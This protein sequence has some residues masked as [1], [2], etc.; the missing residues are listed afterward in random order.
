[1]SIVDTFPKLMINKT[2]GFICLMYSIHI[3]NG[4][5]IWTCKGQIIDRNGSVNKSFKLGEKCNNWA[6]HFFEPYN[7]YIR[8]KKYL[9]ELK[10]SKVKFLFRKETTAQIKEVKKKIELRDKLE[11]TVGELKKLGFNIVEKDDSFKIEKV[12]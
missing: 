4:I 11:H 5:S 9:K 12:V 6:F 7:G 3:P 10:K 2:Y 1:M 8:E